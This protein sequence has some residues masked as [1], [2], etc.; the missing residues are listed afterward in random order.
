MTTVRQQN[1]TTKWET[2]EVLY[3]KFL[4]FTIGSDV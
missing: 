2:L 3:N 1:E 4:L